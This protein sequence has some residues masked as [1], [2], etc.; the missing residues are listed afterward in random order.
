MDKQKISDWI[1]GGSIY[2]LINGVMTI[3]FNKLGLLKDMK[4]WPVI[5]VIV[6]WGGWVAFLLVGVIRHYVQRKK[7]EEVKNKKYLG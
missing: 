3:V 6:A 2:A 7:I 4:S 1:I 5:L